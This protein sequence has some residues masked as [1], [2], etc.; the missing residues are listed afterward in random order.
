[1]MAILTAI[2]DCGCRKEYDA[3]HRY[4]NATEQQRHGSHRL[5]SDTIL[6]SN[7]QQ[8][9]GQNGRSAQR[10]HDEWR[11]AKALHVAGDGIVAQGNDHAE[12]VGG[13][14]GSRYWDKSPTD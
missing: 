3:S 11:N 9:G 1:M 2:T 6:Q 8:A 12:R 14:N 7:D 5:A 4:E 13:G 10:E